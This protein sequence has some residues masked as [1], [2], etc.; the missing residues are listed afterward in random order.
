MKNRLGI[1]LA[2]LVFTVSGARGEIWSQLK[3]KPFEPLAHRV[4]T[5]CVTVKIYFENDSLEQRD[6][7]EMGQHGEIV[8]VYPIKRCISALQLP[9]AALQELLKGPTGQERRQGYDTNL[10]GLT[11]RR[12]WVRRGVATVELVGELRLRGELSGLRLRL[13]VEKTLKQ[14][15]SIRKVVIRVNGRRDFDSLR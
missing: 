5:P 6:A 7:V 1:F 3:P 2:I 8:R 10:E 12:F 4:L 14:F 11:L 13:Q 9:T 15:R